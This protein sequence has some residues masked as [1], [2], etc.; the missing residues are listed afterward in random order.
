MSDDSAIDHNLAR[1]AAG[2]YAQPNGR[3]LHHHTLNQGIAGATERLDASA[4]DEAT[5]WSADLDSHS[6]IRM[7]DIECSCDDQP[8]VERPF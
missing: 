1:R 3:K 2:L 4:H 8:W 5:N 7:S 6:S